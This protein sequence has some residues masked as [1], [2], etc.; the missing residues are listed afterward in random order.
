MFL[1]SIQG[2]TCCVSRETYPVAGESRQRRANP[3][4]VVNA[5]KREI[6]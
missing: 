4:S 3:R 5:E 6:F 2:S 1:K